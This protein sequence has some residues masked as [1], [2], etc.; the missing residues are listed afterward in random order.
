MFNAFRTASGIINCLFGC[1][2]EN[3][4]EYKVLDYIY[5]QPAESEEYRLTYTT[6]EW[7]YLNCDP[8]MITP[9]RNE[10][11]PTMHQQGCVY[12]CIIWSGITH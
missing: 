5:T 8:G 6:H 10:L 9:N 11:K 12:V 3:G 7:W 4:T 2:M 1:E